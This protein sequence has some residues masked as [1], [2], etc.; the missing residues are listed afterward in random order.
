MMAGIRGEDTR[1]EMLI[2]RG[3]FQL[4][5]RHRLG[6]NYRYQGKLLPGRPDLVYRKY[7][8]VIQVNGCFWHRH[9]CHLFKWPDTRKDFWL[10]KLSENAV[11]DVSNLEQLEARG[12][13]VLT[14]WECALKGKWRRE[15]GE[16]INTAA[17]WLQFDVASAEIEGVKPST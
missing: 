16:V 6:K 2:R 10:R 3:L 1:P 17:N 15:P 11:R 7:R 12:W 14:V 9:D 13:R 8:A 5:F 4:G